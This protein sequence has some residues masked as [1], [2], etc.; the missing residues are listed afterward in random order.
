MQIQKGRR[1]GGK[2]RENA[3]CPVTLTWKRVSKL[4]RV[5][6]EQGVLNVASSNSTSPWLKRKKNVE[7]I[8]T[9]L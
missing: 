6:T 7:E 9:H 2:E 4:L 3:W 8:D 1:G 5:L